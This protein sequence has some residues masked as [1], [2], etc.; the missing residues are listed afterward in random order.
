MAR[1]LLA[2][3]S[4]VCVV[5]AAQGL[6]VWNSVLLNEVHYYVPGYDA[7]NEYVELLNAGGTVA[8][9]DG[10]VMTDEGDDGMPEPVF[11]FPG[12]RGG[13]E[14]PI[15][16]GEIVLI[17]IDAVAGE[18]EPDLTHADWEFV[19]PSDDNDNPDVPN[20][21]HC[22]GSDVDIALAN[23]GDGILIATGDDTTAAIDCD[24]VVDGVNWAGVSD[25]VPITWTSCE[26]PAFAAG[27]P[28][29]NS[30]GRC[31][32][33]ID[34]NVSSAEDWFMTIP[35]PGAPNMPSWPSDCSVG[36]TEERASWGL[37]KAIYR[38]GALAAVGTPGVLGASGGDSRPRR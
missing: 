28:Q 18:I 25:P 12:E 34:G 4:I 24:T 31:P 23:G 26:D 30:L 14:Y 29:G 3:L 37:I 33:G 17:A 7:H 1:L 32:G 21:R 19:H 35:S 15:W 11:R 6:E 2:V 36:V 9:L 8:F 22:A 20:L 38:P 13:F 16:P 5:G 27:V 10:A